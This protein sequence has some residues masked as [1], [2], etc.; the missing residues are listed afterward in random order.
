MLTM[1]GAATKLFL[2]PAFMAAQ[3]GNA[4][5]FPALADLALQTAVVWA[6]AYL[7]SKTR[8]TVY[9]LAEEKLGKWAAKGIYALLA[10]YFLFIAVVPLVEQQNFIHDAFYETVL[11]LGMFVPVFAFTFYAGLKPLK[12]AGAF[13][14]VCMPIFVVSVLAII[15]MSAAGGNYS[16][17]L[18]VLR[19][20]L[21]ALGGGVVSSLYRF[22]EGAFMLIF[23]GN[24]QYK[25]GDAAKLTLSYA[26]GGLIVVAVMAIFY[27]VYGP[28]ARTRTFAI[29]NSALFF[30]PLDY[31]GRLDLFAAYAFDLVALFAIALYVQAFTHCMSKVF[32]REDRNFVFSA[33][34]NV[35]LFAV[36]VVVRNKYSVLQQTAAAWF[37][38]P[39]VLFSY[40]L[41][42]SA[43]LLRPRKKR[44]ERQ[45]GDDA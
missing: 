18:P 6:T 13:A 5:I 11:A 4:L 40:I 25:K 16:N 35:A 20:P 2:Y 26:A 1:Y 41:P 21:S 14:D 38:L 36:V 33:I 23:V 42:L 34:A 39:V 27:A 30:S 22:S 3:L 32:G 9:A 44:P 24:F 17:L 28:L 29:V 15:G 37:F 43:W 10:L 45:G 19:Q 8:K 31:L 7:S 12:D